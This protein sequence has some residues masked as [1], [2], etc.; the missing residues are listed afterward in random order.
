MSDIQTE[1]IAEQETLFSIG[2]I[3]IGTD[4]VS[5]RPLHDSIAIVIANSQSVTHGIVSTVNIDVVTVIEHRAQR[6]THPIGVH[7]PDDFSQTFVVKFLQNNVV[8]IAG[9]IIVSSGQSFKLQF[10]SSVHQII[11]RKVCKLNFIVPV[12]RQAQ[13]TAS[14]LNGLHHDDTVCSFRT[15]NGSR[16]SIFQDGDA[17]HAVH[18]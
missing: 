5:V 13:L 4:D 16:C 8:R 15:I 17:C 9:K 2:Q 3:D 18:A 11:I 10:F 1:F 12:I 6:F 14:R 7:P